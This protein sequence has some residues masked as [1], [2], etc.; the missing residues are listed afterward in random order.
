MTDNEKF[1]NSHRFSPT[2]ILEFRKKNS[3][4]QILVK[5]FN[6]RKKRKAI[7]PA[8][9]CLHNVFTQCWCWT[10]WNLQCMYLLQRRNRRWQFWDSCQ[11]T[12]WYFVYLQGCFCGKSCTVCSSN[13]GLNCQVS[14]DN[15][16]C[17]PFYLI[18]QKFFF[19]KK[20]KN[21]INVS[22]N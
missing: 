11:T 3:G 8:I 9:M 4:S 20:K 6:M 17:T 21:F 7:M 5:V 22:V 2:I 18:I 13:V 19:F 16:R 12:D 10:K 1:H 15:E 14:L